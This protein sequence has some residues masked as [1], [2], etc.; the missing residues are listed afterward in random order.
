MYAFL[1]CIVQ[2]Q[3][4]GLSPIECVK[5]HISDPAHQTVFNNLGQCVLGDSVD[6]FGVAVATPC[7]W[8]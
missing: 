1:G 2:Y 7:L 3:A 6:A 4:T 5:T 8:P